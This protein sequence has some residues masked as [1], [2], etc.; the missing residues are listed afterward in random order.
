LPGCGLRGEVALN[1][2]E[3]AEIFNERRRFYA[4]I[5]DAIERGGDSLR[6]EERERLV[7]SVITDYNLLSAAEA[8]YFLEENQKLV[9]NGWDKDTPPDRR[10]E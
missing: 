6:P 4:K 2:D 5:R 1:G 10:P 7:R 8:D 9:E 3:H